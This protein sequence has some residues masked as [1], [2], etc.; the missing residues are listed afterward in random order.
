MEVDGF[1]DI[2]G[3]I[4]AASDSDGFV[5]AEEADYQDEAPDDLESDSIASFIDRTADSDDTGVQ[6]SFGT[7]RLPPNAVQSSSSQP[8]TG[9]P[10]NSEQRESS[11]YV[12]LTI[13]SS[14]DS[15]SGFHHISDVQE[16]ERPS[17]MASSQGTTPVLPAIKQL[18]PAFGSPG[19]Q[20]E[21]P[22]GERAGGLMP[23]NTLKILGTEEPLWIP[24]IQKPPVLSEDMLREREAILIGLGTSEEGTAQRAR[25]QCAELISDMESFKAA[26]PNCALGDFVR[27]HSPRDWL[28]PEGG[29]EQDGCLSPRMSEG[30]NNLW[31][32]LWSQAKRVPARLQKPLFDSEMEAEKALHYLEGVPVYA[33]FTSLLPTIFTIAYER[34]Y[35]QPII[36]RMP[37]LRSRL[38][39]LGAKILRDVDWATADPDSP[40]YS[41]ILDDVE[42]LE[43]QTSR[44]IALLHKF[45]DQLKLV[46]RLVCSG[47]TSVDDR[48][49]QRVVLKALGQFNISAMA[50]R[51][52]EYVFTANTLG[53]A[54]VGQEAGK[55]N[56]FAQRMHVVIE[57]DSSIR[58]VTSRT[59]TQS[60]Q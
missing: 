44:C 26:N 12:D 57:E 16:S 33:L 58:V 45:P 8:R 43:V 54:A 30:T 52:R 14:V 31:Q 18:S 34:L 7:M 22:D 40:A 60:C 23:S 32:Q 53:V 46:E 15:N 29:Q 24:E 35:R 3:D 25:L 19:P 37:A 48:R 49:E 28:V 21:L 13:S 41:A 36:H 2:D 27:W 4:G 51:R 59:K 1:E 17:V 38:I 42:T 11:N 56:K 20:H 39:A 9:M 6:S 50:P 5:S 10:I 47:Q 55:V